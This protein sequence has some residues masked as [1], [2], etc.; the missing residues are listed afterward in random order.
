MRSSDSILD[1][2][3]EDVPWWLVSRL[4]RDPP[5]SSFE[6]LIVLAMLNQLLLRRSLV[7]PFC[8]VVDEL[9]EQEERGRFSADFPVFVGSR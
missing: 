7:N 4:E 5:S 3:H 2:R 8:E 1:S 9:D 6:G